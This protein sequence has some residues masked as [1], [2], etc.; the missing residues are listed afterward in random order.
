MIADVRCSRLVAVQTPESR[1]RLA[2]VPCSQ[3]VQGFNI[4]FIKIKK[5]TKE[6][7]RSCS[8]AFRRL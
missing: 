3:Q 4:F 8:W 6:K 5:K 2:S 1:G 7:P